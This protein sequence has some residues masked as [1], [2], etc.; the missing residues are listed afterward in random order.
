MILTLAIVGLILGLIPAAMMLR[1]VPLFVNWRER[2]HENV[3]GDRS[4]EIVSVSVLIPA[5]DEASAIG[6][7]IGAALASTGVHVQ[8]VV[9]DDASTDGTGDVVTAIAAEDDRVKL[10]H[11]NPLP[12]GWNGKQHACWQLAAAATHERIVFLDADVR[13]SSGALA[14]LV[15]Y[16]DRRGLALLSAFPHQETETWLE[17]WIIP[18]MHVILLGFLPLSR[19]RASNHPAYASGCGQL[20]M[21][22]KTAY[23]AAGTH[24]AIQGS[25]HDGLKLP[26]AYRQAGLSTDVVDGT[27]LAECRMYTDAG[28]VIRGVLK[29]ASEGIA[30]PRLIVPFT[31]ILVGGT[32]L[33]W[34][35]LGWAIGSENV[36]AGI[37]SA[38]A[39]V[40][41]H[42]PRAVAAA[43][44]RQPVA[45]VIFHAPATALFIALQWVALFNAMTGKQIA[46]RGRTE[47]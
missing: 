28:Q 14:Q 12:S 26:R 45:G 41:G 3:D 5:R 9:L 43:R 29:N 27:S 2:S 31:V 21:T 44:F 39:V 42:F 19:M 20:F 11:G 23:A 18:M 13:L 4:T 37:V 46:W 38:I 1:N 36:L 8:V 25:R 34:V 47:T 15:A 32:V 10:I 7:S 6:H 35:T 16:Q 30:N 33:P 17:Q 22:T 24:Q 40:V